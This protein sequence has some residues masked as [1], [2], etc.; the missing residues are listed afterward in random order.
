MC[1]YQ[2]GTAG[3]REIVIVIAWIATLLDLFVT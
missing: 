2:K 3:W 1:G